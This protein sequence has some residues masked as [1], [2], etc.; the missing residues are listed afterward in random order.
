MERSRFWTL[1]A[2]TE[3]NTPPQEGCSPHPSLAPLTRCFVRGQ[4]SISGIEN[5][6]GPPTWEGISGPVGGVLGD[7]RLWEWRTSGPMGGS[8]AGPAQH[9]R[10]P[11]PL[12]AIVLRSAQRGWGRG[13]Y[14][15]GR[16]FMSDLP[17]DQTSAA[18]EAGADRSGGRCRSGAPGGDWGHRP[19]TQRSWEETTAQSEQA[20]PGP[21]DESRM[22]PPRPS[23]TVDPPRDLTCTKT[24]A[25][26]RREA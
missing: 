15:R 11:P 2:R 25:S 21:S 23:P 8:A 7:C 17:L 9:S 5:Q 14:G 19:A 12:P 3:R 20:R 24:Y 16:S 22:F 10:R 6:K 13:G 1:S 18:Q 4:A 26:S